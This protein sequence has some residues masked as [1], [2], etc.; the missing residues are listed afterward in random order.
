MGLKVDIKKKMGNFLLE[1]SFEIDCETLA[2]LGSS[3]SGKSMTLKCIAGIETPDEGEIILDGLVLFNSKNKIN[4][5]PQ[6]RGIG[7]LFQ[8][9]ALFPNMTVEENIAVTLSGNKKEKEEII[10]EKI[11]TFYLEGLENKKPAQLS[12][13]Q[14]QRV[15]LARMIA[16]NPKVIMLDEPFSALDSHLRWQLEQELL[17]IIEKYQ[18]PT[19]FVSHNR[20]EVYRISDRIAVLDKGKLE[21]ISDKRSLFDN[22]ELLTGAILTG[23]K[24]FSR[25]VKISDF[26]VLAIDWNVELD[27]RSI[28]MDNVGYIGVRAHHIQVVKELNKDENIILCRVIKIIDNTF[29]VIV[30]LKNICMDVEKINMDKKFE[31]YSEIRLELGKQEWEEVKGEQIRIKLPKKDLLLLH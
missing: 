24:N 9:Y 16:S 26:K 8:N 14:Q 5:S 20:D 11:K 13:G 21:K 27:T 17:D 29:S 15:A 22:P 23:C 1:V 12:G 30:I 6:E 19:L 28:V 7:Y 25:I 2:I 4:L 3:G 31:N 18:R 10:K